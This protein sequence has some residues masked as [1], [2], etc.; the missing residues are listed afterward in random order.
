MTDTKVARRSAFQVI[1][2]RLRAIREPA[3]LLMAGARA[4]HV[5]AGN[6]ICSIELAGERARQMTLGNYQYEYAIHIHVAWRQAQS[7]EEAVELE[8]NV[9]EMARSIQTA[10]TS[11]GTTLE[12]TVSGAFPEAWQVQD[13]T[14]GPAENGVPVR[15]LTIPVLIQELEGEAIRR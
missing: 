5:M 2:K 7:M 1:Q 4:Q 6:P 12:E 9:L 15:V 10:L 11:E 14:L 8:M 3:Q 13:A